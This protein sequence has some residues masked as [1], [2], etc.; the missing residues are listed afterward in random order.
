M[1]T[2]TD[3]FFNTLLTILLTTS[4]ETAYKEAMGK[5]GREMFFVDKYKPIKTTACQVSAC[6]VCVV[7]CVWCVV[8]VGVYACLCGGVC[9]CVR[10]CVCDAFSLSNVCVG[11]VCVCVCVHAWVSGW[12]VSVCV[13]CVHVSIFT[14]CVCV[15]VCVSRAGRSMRIRL[16]PMYTRKHVS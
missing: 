16:L 8:C 14:V 4:D 3:S 7:S 9:A 6:L 15:C 1:H 11:C 10:E 5:S 2:S 12:H 13:L